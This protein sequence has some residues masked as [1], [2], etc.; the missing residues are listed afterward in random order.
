MF[1]CLLTSVESTFLDDWVNSI[2]L[3]VVTISYLN[4]NKIFKFW[5]E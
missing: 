2:H 1:S 5:K 3:H 4:G